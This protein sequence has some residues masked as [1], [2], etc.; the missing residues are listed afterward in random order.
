MSV[1]AILNILH[2]LNKI[3]LCEP[4]ASIILFHITCSINSVMNLHEYNILFITYPC[5]FNDAPIV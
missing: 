1:S 3:I 2:K 5:I 4:L